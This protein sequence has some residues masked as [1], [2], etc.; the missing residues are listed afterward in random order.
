MANI[1][2]ESFEVTLKSLIE[3]NAHARS[4]GNDFK[5]WC[6]ENFDCDARI[7]YIKAQQQLTNRV[8]EQFRYFSPVVVFV[9]VAEVNRD[10]LLRYIMERTYSEMENVAVI[11]LIQT[12]SGEY[13]YQYEHLVVLK[14]TSFTEWARPL[15]KNVKTG[16]ELKKELGIPGDLDFAWYVGATGNNEEG[17]WRDFSDEYIEQGTW[18][19]GWDDKFIDTV[20]DIKIGDRIAIK[21]VFNQKNNI[22]FE[23]HGKKVAVMRIKAIGTVTENAGDGKNIKVEWAKLNPEKDWYGPGNLRQTIHGVSAEDG[24]IKRQ[25]LAF[26]FGKDLQDYSLCEEYYADE[27]EGNDETLSSVSS[28]ENTKKE[29]PI[30]KVSCLDI[31]RGERTDKIHPLNFIVFGAPGTG[32]TYSMVE[33][34]LAIVEGR[35]TDFSKVD[36]NERKDRVARYKQLIKEGRVVFTTFHQN[37]GY[38]EFIQ[39]LR[40]DTDSPTMSFKTVDGV[41]KRIADRALED[42]VGNNYV[43][44]IDEINRANISKVFG[45]LI[46]LIEEDK[47]WGELNEMC[48]TLQSGDAFAVPNNLYIVGTM[49]S[50]D[51]SISLIDAALRRRFSFI[52]Q[53]PN[54]TLVDDP[55]MRRVLEKL[56]LKLVDE[57]ESTDLLI[58]HSYFMNKNKDELCDVLNNNIIP[59]LYEYFYDNKKKVA[60]VLQDTITKSGATIELVDEKIGRLKIRIKGDADGVE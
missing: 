39:G 21:S 47:R 2:K 25:L 37:Y 45:E 16:K 55:T 19:N 1:T 51:K 38:E 42:T 33:Y 59:L 5:D 50:A 44:I 7:S 48:V 18:I 20:K 43:I 31:K 36:A 22:P 12:E 14:N 28:N 32:K 27:F 60:A 41:F 24:E 54:A 52:E 46:T 30:K 57:L 3:A 35:N 40:P 26:T 11:G 15:F 58:G 9:C 56:N 29:E 17:E 49:N 8:S 10:T 13:H 6:K 34:A 4:K 53:L 23:N